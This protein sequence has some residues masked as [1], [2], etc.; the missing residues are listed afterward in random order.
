MQMKCLAWKRSLGKR[1]YQ[2]SSPRRRKAWPFPSFQ[3][4]KEHPLPDEFK[5]TGWRELGH[6]LKCFLSALFCRV[7]FIHTKGL[8]LCFSLDK[9]PP[10]SL[11]FLFCTGLF[12]SWFWWL[13]LLVSLVIPCP[14]KFS[15]RDLSVV[16]IPKLFEPSRKV[17]GI[18]VWCVGIWARTWSN[19]VV[20]LFRIRAPKEQVRKSPTISHVP[21]LLG[22]GYTR[23]QEDL[24]LFLRAFEV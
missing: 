5:G 19:E 9:R 21:G 12:K 2:P 11:L 6:V 10:P 18:C 23:Q 14:V 4:G 16:G 13:S 20:C 1:E 17:Y 24:L 3:K 15:Q 8:L 7:S 22:L